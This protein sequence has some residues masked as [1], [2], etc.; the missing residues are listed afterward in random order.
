M[1]EFEVIDTVLKKNPEIIKYAESDVTAGLKGNGLGRQ[2]TPSLEQIVRAG[3]YK[4]MKGE[5]YTELELSQF[6][7][8]MFESF[9]KVE[10][11]KPY[12]FQVYQKYISRIKEETLE[13]IMI[14]VNK[15]AIEDGIE[16]MEDFRQDSTVIETNIHYPTNNS[17]IWDCIDKS[18]RLLEQL[19]EE[20][21][22]LEVKD[23]R[24]AAKHD[25]FWIN[26]TPL[27]KADKRTKMFI[28]QLKKLDLAME[29]LAKVLKK[30]PNMA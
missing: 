16:D 1:P 22:W 20:A 23:Y 3:I 18:Q 28:N 25:Y 24:K 21:K 12:S 5:D 7:S 8:R 9:V 14:A 17:L 19:K 13:K 26:V 10:R 30:S 27:K 11:E 2:D 29:Q 6:D 15:I 4:E